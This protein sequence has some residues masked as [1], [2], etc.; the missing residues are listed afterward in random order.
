MI[1]TQPGDGVSL[2]DAPLPRRTIERI[3]TLG[4]LAMQAAQLKTDEQRADLYERYEMQAMTN[5]YRGI[6]H[7]RVNGKWCITKKSTRGMRD[8][9]TEADRA[10]L[11][12]ELTTEPQWYKEIQA[13]LG[14]SQYKTRTVARQL[15]IRTKREPGGKAYWWR[16]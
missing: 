12:A 1:T 11:L 14:W 16:E 6:P 10:A 7:Q 15:T 8:R 2:P 3:N 5:F 4:M 13:R 9:I